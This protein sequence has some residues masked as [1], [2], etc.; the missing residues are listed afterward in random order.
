MR[1]AGLDRGGEFSTENLAYKI[2]RNKK[3]LDKLY[4]TKNQRFDQELSLD[5]NEESYSVKTDVGEEYPC[6]DKDHAVN[7]A[8]SLLSYKKADK[9]Y[10]LRNG[11]AIYSWQLNNK[12]QSLDEA[13]T[14]WSQQAVIPWMKFMKINV[15]VIY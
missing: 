2:I 13:E 4:K 11:K 8:R 10:I 1:Q 3:F 14:D 12:M 15:V 6:G 9:V 7:K 5:E